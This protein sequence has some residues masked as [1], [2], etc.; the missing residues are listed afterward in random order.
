ML[1]FIFSSLYEGSA[2]SILTAMAYNLPIATAN[3]P[4]ITSVLGKNGTEF[5]RPMSVID[6]TEALKKQLSID[7]KKTA[8]RIYHLF[9]SRL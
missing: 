1:R 6:M 3:L 9:P 4:S 2:E 8:K 5:F 7:S